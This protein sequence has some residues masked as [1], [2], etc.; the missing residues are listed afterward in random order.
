MKNKWFWILSIIIALIVT[1]FTVI[2][3]TETDTRK[4]VTVWTL[5]MGDFA[6][7]MNN[8]ISKYESTHPDIKIKWIAF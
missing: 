4:E 5:Q 1:Y 8:I 3:K 2:Q 7:Y 6:D